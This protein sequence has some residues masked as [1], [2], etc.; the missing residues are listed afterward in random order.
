MPLTTSCIDPS[1]PTTTSSSAP[2]SAARRASSVSSPA[3][4]EKSAS[5]VSP[6]AAARRAISGQRLPV[7]PFADAGLMR[8]TVL[9]VVSASLRQ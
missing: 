2:S 3:V 4:R 7:E 8:K 6:A 5:P 9:G 1:P